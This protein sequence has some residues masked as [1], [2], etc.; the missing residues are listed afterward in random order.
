MD[1]R[2]EIFK[3]VVKYLLNFMEVSECLVLVIIMRLCCSRSCK[4]FIL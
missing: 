3:F 1:D 2:K 4:S